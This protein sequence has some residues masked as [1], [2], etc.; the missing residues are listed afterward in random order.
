MDK[1]L[2][3]NFGGQ[4]ASIKN[5]DWLMCY[6]NSPLYTTKALGGDGCGYDAI[7]F[8]RARGD[9]YSLTTVY[10]WSAMAML[11]LAHGQGAS[12]T[13]YCAWYDPAH[14]TNFPKGATAEY[15]GDY[16]DSSI[17][18]SPHAD[19]NAL[20][21]TGSANQPAKVSHNGQLCGIVDV[22]GMC[23]QLCTNAQLNHRLQLD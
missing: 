11:S 14:N 3:S 1:Y 12:S 15:C 21:K 13:S 4:A 5:A 17:V 22:A 6:S 16:N 18:Y 23:N 19:S 20:A 7:T 2:C 9:H 10:Q 8:S